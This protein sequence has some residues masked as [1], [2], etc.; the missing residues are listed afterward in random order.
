M[1]FLIILAFIGFLA[2]IFLLLGMSPFEFLENLTKAFSG[3]RKPL[4][5]QIEEAGNP[6]EL[7]GI[8][9]TVSE[10]K[11]VLE[12]T[13]KSGKFAALCA[14]S[15]FLMVVG[16]LFCVL[17]GNYFMLPVLAVG[18]ALV[19]FWYIVFTSHSYKKMM[20]GEIETALSVITTSYLRS[21]S[22]ITAVEENIAYLHPPVADV[23]RSFLA[24]TSVISTDVKQALLDMKPKLKNYIF[25]EWIDAAVACQD[26]KT[27]KSTLTPIIE[28]L[29]D[30]RVVS[31][32]LDYLM[33][34][35][36]KEFI[37]MALLLV[38]NIPLLYFLNKDWY[39]TLMNTGVGQAIL[40]VCVFTLFISFAAVVRLTKPVEYK[41]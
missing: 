18:M 6:K 13:G 25:H 20:N 16:I 7:K 12:M 36:L 26:D 34:E 29:S 14:L 4:A 38:G 21:E 5:K 32:E 19:P 27:L 39:H 28:K 23:F 8:R 24:Q 30:M 31:A 33:Y 1:A 2:G 15:F 40:A 37:T 3:R 17:I 35:P 41:R 11:E 10:T 9:R 22:I